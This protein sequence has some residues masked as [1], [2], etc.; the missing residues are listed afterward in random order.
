MVE[1]KRNARVATTH[2]VSVEV[3]PGVN[4]ISFA[5]E[6]ISMLGTLSRDDDEFDVKEYKFSLE[7]VRSL[8]FINLLI[9]LFSLS[10]PT[11]FYLL[12]LNRYGKRRARKPSELQP[13]IFHSLP[14]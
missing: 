4:T 3:K 11:F 10:L 14:A 1:W 6:E 7:D 5:N 2:G 12:F 9:Y 13:L 8:L